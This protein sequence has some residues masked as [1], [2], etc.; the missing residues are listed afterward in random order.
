MFIDSMT[1]E[2]GKKVRVFLELKEKPN[3]D[4][5]FATDFVR[6]FNFQ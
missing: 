3:K 4:G 6:L 1:N 5:R 2:A